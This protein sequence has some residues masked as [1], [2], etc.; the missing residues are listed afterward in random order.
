MFNLSG[1]EL[2]FLVLIALV[3][4][5]PDKLPEAVRKATKAYNDFKKMAGGFQ[6]EMRTVLEEPMREMRET[7]DLVKSSAMF[8][9]QSDAKPTATKPGKTSVSTPAAT[10]VIQSETTT[11]ETAEPESVP[12]G[13]APAAPTR[14]P[15]FDISNYVGETDASYVAPEP[16][17]AAAEADE[18]TPV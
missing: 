1:S 15:S 18:A 8:D 11:S 16:T 2:I 9:P 3:V 10:P 7:A 14:A 6:D 4:L 17:A 5:G 13:E 12:V